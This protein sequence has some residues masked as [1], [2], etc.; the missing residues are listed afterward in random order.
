MKR[1]GWRSY[2]V[3]TPPNICGLDVFVVKS[4]LR[5]KKKTKQKNNNGDRNAFVDAV[6]CTWAVRVAVMSTLNQ[7]RA[8]INGTWIGVDDTRRELFLTLYAT[9]RTFLN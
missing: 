8:L 2:I 1:T 5:N 6:Y 7:N 3:C 4:A 9:A